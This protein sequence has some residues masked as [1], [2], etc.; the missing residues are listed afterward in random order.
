MQDDYSIPHDTFLDEPAPGVLSND[1]DYDGDP[2]TASLIIGPTEAVAFML[3]PDGSFYYQPPSL[4]TGEDSFV[5]E[6]SDGQATDQ[7]TVSIYVENNT[8]GAE[9]DEYQVVHDTPLVVPAPGVLANDWDYDGDPLSAVLD[10]NPTNGTLSYFYLDGS[11]EYV[12]NAGFAGTDTFTYFAN[13]HLVNSPA[14]TVIIHV[15]KVNMTIYNGQTGAAVAESQETTLG[16]F[17]VANFNDTDGDGAPDDMDTN[18]VVATPNGRDEVDLMKLVLDQPKPDYGGNVTLTVDSGSVALWQE[19]TKVNQIELVGDSVQFPTADLPKTIWAEATDS[20]QT[21][22]DIQLSL[23][24][25]S[26]SDTVAAT[27]TWVV[28][29]GFRH[30]Q[31]TTTLTGAAINSNPGSNQIEVADSSGFAVGDHIVLFRAADDGATRKPFDITAINGAIFSL[32]ATI[33]SGWAQGD[34]VRVGLSQDA[35]RDLHNHFVTGGGGKLGAAHVS[36]MTNN[37]M[38][39]EFWVTPSGIGGEPGIV[40]DITRQKESIGW[41]LDNGIWSSAS[42]PGVLPSTFPAQNEAPNDDSVATDEDNTPQNDHIYSFD[43]PGFIS[44]T[45]SHDRA[46]R[47][48]NFYEFVRVK[49]DGTNFANQNNLVEGSRASGKIAWRSRLDVVKNTATGKWQR[50]NTQPPREVENEIMPL[51]KNLLQNDPTQ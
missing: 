46:V 20:S 17:T 36:P 33:G 35:A 37:G 21:I 18:G 28:Q 16:A 42:V 25:G 45:A 40:F 19:S 22:R 50:N 14:A 47:H 8:P 9:D 48:F 4:W 23:H 49:V 5:Y 41:N 38:E 24:Y 11:F 34:E 10:T 12:P 29:T 1:S 27:G 15:V 13:D 39:I 6:V 43:T 51:H 3:Y 44:A 2:L 31:V 30:A 26:E 32:D 7:A